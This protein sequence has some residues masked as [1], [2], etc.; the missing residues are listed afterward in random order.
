MKKRLC[1]LLACSFVLA[2]ACKKTAD[3]KPVKRVSGEPAEDSE[4]GTEPED[5]EPE[6]SEK[7]DI[8]DLPDEV[9]IYPEY[10]FNKEMH[11]LEVFSST[12]KH[13]YT[14]T[15][16]EARTADDVGPEK[17]YTAWMSFES[18]IL[19]DDADYPDLKGT[20]D[21]LLNDACAEYDQK[22]TQYI[23]DY[24][25]G[26]EDEIFVNSKIDVLRSDQK[27]FSFRNQPDYYGDGYLNMDE[28]VYNI[29]VSTCRLIDL[30][31][32]V[33]DMTGF[34]KALLCEASRISGGDLDYVK[35]VQTAFENGKY[36]FLIDY[37]GIT[38]FELPQY[39][40][41]TAWRDFIQVPY[42]GNQDVFDETY[43]C[44]L[45]Y[46]YSFHFDKN[47]SIAW[48]LDDDGKTETLRVQTDSD[49]AFTIYIDKEECLS[50]TD[51]LDEDEEIY[52]LIYVWEDQQQILY[53]VC[54]DA[55]G[56]LTTYIFE[57][58]DNSTV[59]Y[60]N[61]LTAMYPGRKAQCLSNGGFEGM[62]RTEFFQH[63]RVVGSFNIGF[64]GEAYLSDDSF[65]VY[66]VIPLHLEKDLTGAAYDDGTRHQ[67]SGDVTFSA[68]T[69]VE[70][71]LTDLESYVVFRA[72]GADLD[73][74]CA[75]VKITQDENDP[76]KYLINGEDADSYF[77]Y[78]YH[79]N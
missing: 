44:D 23:Q 4:S 3:T 38:L 22:Y 35:T 68:G 16:P 15:Q 6:K 34:E 14:Y 24:F 69:N 66:D 53:V 59:E 2:S 71:I 11:I 43:F 57:I 37:F 60:I 33:T 64:H 51:L 70:V 40:D 10:D 77:T 18:V 62:V 27:I 47:Q 58:K 48:D 75:K 30:S 61:V 1:I 73:E 32:V 36:Y 54:G 42:L 8:N 21:Q 76:S 20:I 26:A 67:V 49:T 29:D 19:F 12:C 56:E 13:I 28:C 39:K 9:M 50:V 78:V 31:D 72:Y 45:P 25:Y 63:M 65:E 52:D 46:G 7:I 5:T 41:G 55:E 74:L 17:T 79:E